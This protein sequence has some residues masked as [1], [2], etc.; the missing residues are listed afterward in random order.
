MG[1][2]RDVKLF[3]DGQNQTV[4]IPQE[5]ELPGEDAVMRKIGDR[6]II[7]PKQKEKKSLVELLDSWEPVRDPFPEISDPPTKPEDLF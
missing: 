1:I 2:E 3:R 7:E 5:F 4:R 6:L